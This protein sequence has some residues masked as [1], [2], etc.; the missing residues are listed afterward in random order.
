MLGRA[1]YAQSSAAVVV[2][3]APVHAQSWGGTV[4]AASSFEFSRRRQ[5]FTSQ[6]F[7]ARKPP[8]SASTRA[9]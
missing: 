9:A 5:R 2:D 3:C 7:V 8:V 4:L 6:M 1:S